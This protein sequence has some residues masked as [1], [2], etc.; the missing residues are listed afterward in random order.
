ML[1][2]PG[3]RVRHAAAGRHGGL[4]E[5][6]GA[7]RQAEAGAA[8]GGAAGGGGGAGGRGAR[9]PHPTRRPDGRRGKYVQVHDQDHRLPEAARHL[10]RQPRPRHQRRPLQAQVRRHD[11]LL[12]HSEGRPPG[13]GHAQMLREERAR[14]GRDVVCAPSCAQG[15]LP[16]AAQECQD[17]RAA[18][19]GR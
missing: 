3:D 17:G 2:Q 9:H 8:A 16:G 1:G 5:D 15:R 6:P 13:R 12:G 11:P 19:A 18:S 10:V 7:G 4:P 14:R